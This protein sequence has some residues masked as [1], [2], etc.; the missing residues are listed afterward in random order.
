MG[1]DDNGGIDWVHIDFATDEKSDGHQCGYSG[2]NGHDGW[3]VES[4][5]NL[6]PWR[7]HN[8]DGKQQGIGNDAG[9]ETID[10]TGSLLDGWAEDKGDL[11]QH[12][13]RQHHHRA[14]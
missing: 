3:Q 12:C 13:Q 9:E 4:L 6:L 1:T 5:D 14:R 10:R 2:N 8:A 7:N 11:A